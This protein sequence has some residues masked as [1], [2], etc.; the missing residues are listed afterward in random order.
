VVTGASPSKR[1]QQAAATQEQLLAAAREVFEERGY[2]A[3]T[4]GAIT[5]AASTAHGTFY[6]YFKNK[7]DVF[8][9]VMAVAADELYQE[10]EAPW[11]HGHPR[12]AIEAS[13]RGTL[14]VFA[15]HRSLWRCLLEASF[16]SP[17]VEEMWLDIRRRFMDRI[18]RNLRLLREQGLIRPLDTT[19]TAYALGAMVEWTAFTRFLHDLPPA[20]ETSFDDV[21]VSL[22]DVWFHA[23]HGDA[24]PPQEV[25]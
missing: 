13:I 15:E 24:P 6:L 1:Q 10:A 25:R 4:V 7:E 11:G 20:A 17:A 12:L 5:A 23:V 22:A 2:Q 19:A 3:A 18:D 21:V 14:Q 16:Q 8:G 9:R